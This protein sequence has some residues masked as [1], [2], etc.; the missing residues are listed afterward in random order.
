MKKFILVINDGGSNFR[1]SI[2]N[3]E[4]LEL[5]DSKSFPSD[6]FK[7]KDGLLYNDIPETIE[8]VMDFLTKSKFTKEIKVIV[9]VVR[10]ATVEMLDVNCNLINQSNGIQ[11]YANEFKEDVDKIFDEISPPQQRYFYVGSDMKGGLI[12]ARTI[13]F[14]ANDRKELIRDAKSICFL[15]EIIGSFFIEKNKELK[16]PA[17]FT[18]LACHTGLF[19]F[20]RKTWSKIAKRIDK[21][22]YNKIGR[23]LI[24]DLIPEKIS[25]SYDI[26]GY[27]SKEVSCKTGL[28]SGTVVLHGIHD[29]TSADIPI[30]NSF[31]KDKRK[32]G[33]VH[34]QGG[35]FGMARY[36]TGEKGEIILPP[37]G[38]GILI[39]GD[40]FG[41]PVI[42]AMTPTGYE[43]SYYQ[44]LFKR[45]LGIEEPRGKF[46]I[47]FLSNI[48]KNGEYFI[49]PGSRKLGRGTGQFPDAVGRV[50]E[51]YGES[52]LGESIYQEKS[53][54][55]AYYTLNLSTAIQAFAGIKTVIGRKKLPIIISGGAGKNE[56]FVSLLSTLLDENKVF[57]ILNKEGE[58][59]LETASCGGA[60]LGKSYLE[61]KKSP[62]EIDINILGY[63]LREI[64]RLKI[65]FAHFK[66][67]TDKF[68]SFCLTKI[69]L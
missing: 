2:Y 53:G 48:I 54:K 25:L 6:V 27:V 44:E 35:S 55:L 56:I 49:I 3:S 67:Y 40:L 16:I 21:F 15:P 42:T 62:Y 52:E 61:G 22:L 64:P 46:D 60:I 7:G 50:I 33:L 39:Q 4:N 43:F 68:L 34:F 65:D 11:S 8:K 66:N 18:Y 38:K 45:K 37:D 29:S 41:N 26:L 1:C 10:G 17:E 30:I 32:G 24:G 51:P 23:K 9:P 5:L 47:E 59:L 19:D 20:K 13:I 58:N 69:K 14:W 28:S 31:L 63:K 12:L 36:I 57:S